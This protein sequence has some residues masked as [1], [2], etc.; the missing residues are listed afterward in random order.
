MK[1]FFG[2]LYFLSSA[3]FSNS[4]NILLTE[5]IYSNNNLK[6]IITKEIKLS[7]KSCKIVYFKTPPHQSQIKYILSHKNKHDVFIGANEFELN[8]LLI[9]KP[10]V[11]FELFDY[12]PYVILA[13]SDAFPGF[14]FSK[15]YNWSEVAGTLKKKLLISNLKL[16]STGNG[17][18]HL[19]HINN[20]M[21]KSLKEMIS[22]EFPSWSSMYSF[23]SRKKQGF[24][25][26]YLTSMIYHRCKEKNN[27]IK[28]IKVKGGYPVH[29]EYIVFLNSKKRQLYKNINSAGLQKVLLA[30][31]WMLPALRGPGL[32]SCAEK[33]ILENNYTNKISKKSHQYSLKDLVDWKDKWVF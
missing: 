9:E 25:W 24:V 19:A 32:S 8:T 10:N 5:S 12:S 16:S 11:S 31:N 30:E 22:Q 28:S 13:S 4:L 18:L 7:C 15:T 14:D 29:R 27:L 17:F 33:I 1:I 26:T 2:F 3:I 23:F 6:N 21:K 20:D